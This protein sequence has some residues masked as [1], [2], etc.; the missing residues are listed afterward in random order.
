MLA[1]LLLLISRLINRMELRISHSKVFSFGGL[2]KRS[3]QALISISTILKFSA[4]IKLIIFRD[5]QAIKVLVDYD[6]YLKLKNRPASW[7]ENK[8]IIYGS[9]R[10]L[11]IYPSIYLSIYLSMCILCLSVCPSVRFYP[12]NVKTP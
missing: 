9:N 4:L 5:Y 10:G 12:I 8:V 3:D 2:I 1:L 6:E 7:S 11:S